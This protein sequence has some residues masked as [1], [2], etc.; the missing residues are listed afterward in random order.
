MK[1]NINIIF[2]MWIK[3][4]TIFIYV[5][6]QKKFL[7]HSWYFK[8]IKMSRTLRNVRDVLKQEC[9]IVATDWML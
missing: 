5:Q 4:L 3:W 9:I 2:I 6:L 7:R 8:K 1:E